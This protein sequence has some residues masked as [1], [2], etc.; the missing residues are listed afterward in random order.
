MPPQERKAL[1]AEIE[2]AR[3]SRLICCLTS[4]R[5][6]AVG[7]IAKDFMPIFFNHLRKFGNSER[8]D[9]LLFTSGGDTL[10]AFGL[11]RLLRE[12]AKSVGVLIPE[13]C[14]SAGTLLALGA[15]EIVM[16]RAA[17]LSPIDPSVSGPLNPAIEMGFG[18]RQPV[19]VSVE[20]V[21]GFKALVGEWKLNDEAVG[22]SFKILADKVHPLLLGDVYRGRQQIE[23]LA[24]QLLTSHRNDAQVKEIIATLT[25]KLGSHDYLILRSEARKF[26]GGQIAPEDS[27][28]EEV[29]WALYENFAEEMNLGTVYEPAAAVNSAKLAGHALP[30]RVVNKVVIIESGEGSEVFEHEFLLSEAQA[31]TPAGPQSGIRHDVLRVGWTTLQG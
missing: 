5:P 9:V 18:M 14:H 28:L 25:K 20:S 29:I 26:M 6:N 4:D 23:L 19:P 17:T 2:A 7:V 31:M 24:E 15:N 3:K 11:A 12:F 21:A 16:T 27:S 30:A 13:K 10:A 22:A 8:I 1:I